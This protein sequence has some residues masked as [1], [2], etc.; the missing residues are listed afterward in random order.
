LFNDRARV[1]A[2]DHVRAWGEIEFRQIGTSTKATASTRQHHRPYF[3][4]GFG[5]VE[6]G[7]QVVVHLAR[8]AVQSLWAVERDQSHGSAFFKSH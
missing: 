7:P 1:G 4:I 3:W 6:C 5:L 2:F 8:K